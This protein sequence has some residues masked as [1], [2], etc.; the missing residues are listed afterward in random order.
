MFLWCV[1]SLLALAILIVQI[2]RPRARGI[3]W[4]GWDVR[5]RVPSLC[6]EF[7]NAVLKIAYI[8]DRRL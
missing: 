3:V 4:V 8:F 6:L 1:C 2:L 5:R 7:F